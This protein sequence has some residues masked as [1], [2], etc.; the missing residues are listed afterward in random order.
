MKT[1]VAIAAI[2]TL[3]GTSAWAADMAVK[4]SPTPVAAPAYNWT[5]VYV[6]G[7]VGY[8]WGVNTGSGYT[9]FTDPFLGFN[10][11]AFF[12]SGGNQLPGTNP[13]G[14]IGGGQIGDDWQITPV[15]VLGIVADL[16]ASNMRASANATSAVVLPGAPVPTTQSN[17]AQENWFGTVR[18]KVG[19]A[20]NNVLMY[21]T[22]G[23]AYGK[24][25]ANTALNCPACA[26]AAGLFFAGAG[27]STRTGWAAGAGLEYGLAA[28]WTIGV[29][30]LHVDLGSISVTAIQSGGAPGFGAVTW[31]SKSKFADDIARF[32]LNYKFN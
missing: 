26:G 11:P 15:S 4:A 1:A 27:S 16:Q 2:A 22:G 23:L 10:I 9:S 14:I 25:S 6:G 31:T 21:G 19:Y 30:Y 18:G 29:E 3:I 7:N 24:V 12:A 5:G 28:N 20:I 8:G 32:V 13:K 17:S